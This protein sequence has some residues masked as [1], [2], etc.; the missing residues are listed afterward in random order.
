MPDLADDAGKHI[1]ANQR[2]CLEK[3]TQRSPDTN[4]TGICFICDEEIS[5]VRI[6]AAG[7]NAAG[8][9]VVDNCYECQSELEYLSRQAKRF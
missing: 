8:V 5:K 4:T 1:E 9:P 2:A 6:L 7:K 3:V